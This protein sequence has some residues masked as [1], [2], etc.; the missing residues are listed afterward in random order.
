MVWALHSRRQTELLRASC[1]Y[2]EQDRLTW[3]E[4]K[5]MGTPFWLTD[6]EALVSR[7]EMSLG[8]SDLHSYQ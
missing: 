3:T 1:Q 2:W 8:L 6:I 4:A 7:A 5:R